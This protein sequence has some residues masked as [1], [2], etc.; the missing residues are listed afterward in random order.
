WVGEILSAENKRQLW[1]PEGFAH[2]FYVLSDEA[3]FVY[4]CTDYY[5][6]EAEQV[7]IWNDPAIGIDWPLQT[8]PLL[9]PKDLAGKAWAQAEKLR[10]TL[11]R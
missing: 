11:S 4:K 2:G 1:V 5:K 9:S 8:E 10:L 7:L 3:E 6:P